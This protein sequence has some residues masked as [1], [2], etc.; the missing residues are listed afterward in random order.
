MQPMGLLAGGLVLLVIG[1]VLRSVFRLNSGARTRLAGSEPLTPGHFAI[2]T[3]ISLE[4]ETQAAII[5]ISLNDAFGE[6]D[7]GHHEIAWRLVT[8]AASELERVAEISTAL[9]DA[10]QKNMPQTRAL[11]P[12]RGIVARRFKSH[13]M[14]EYLRM[15]ELLDKLVF[16]SRMRFQLQVHM[17][18]KAAANLTT[19][20]NRTYHYGERTD[21]HPTELWQRLDIYSHD[22]DLVTK[23]TLMA[24]RAFLICLPLSALPAIASDL[25]PVLRRRVRMPAVSAQL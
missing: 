20:F 12:Y 6:R 22:F 17:L 3:P 5:S 24:F 10:M 14:I 13:S 4:V 19:E 15:Y 18:R 1:F 11:V 23:E 21:D 8:L 16:R 25:E 2:Y 9:L 7:S